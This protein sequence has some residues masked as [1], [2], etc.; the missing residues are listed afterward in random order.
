[1]N[2]SKPYTKLPKLFKRRSKKSG[3]P[4]GSLVH[5]GDEPDSKFEIRVIDYNHKHSEEKILNDVRECIKYKRSEGITWINI[6]GLHD[7][8]QLERL[9]NEYNIHPLV[10][11]DILNTNQ[12]PKLENYDNYVYIIL[13]FFYKSSNDDH[14]N[15]EQI[16]IIMGKSYVITFQEGIAGDAFETV[17]Q[18]IL[19]NKGKITKMPS[20]Y[21]VYSLI[22]AV[23]D[24]YF[25]LLDIIG[26]K[27]EKLEEELI[28]NPTKHTLTEIY[29]LKREML[30]LRKSI[31]PLREVIAAMERG[32]SSLFTDATRFYLRDIYD[33]T[34]N[35]I[36]TLETYR[37][38]LSGILDIYLS[39]MSNRLNEKIKYLT[40][41]TT[42]FIPTSLIAS[43]FGM[44]FIHLPWLEWEYGYL[45]I[46]GIM[47]VVVISMWIFF[48][49]KKLI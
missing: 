49:V 5:I 29:T 35:T 18:R 10:M 45:L 32:E 9:G 26:E 2:L 12:R 16:S 42:I 6:N 38:M 27:I 14:I 47:C 1:M 39:S 11:E 36:D 44:N 46:L 4:P 8:N 43:I 7:V 34:I 23:I 19:N 33:H 41:L 25:D 21:L 13:K 31:W 30:I 40:L 3:L 24:S 17:R 15:T 28:N 48:K 37:D 22:D 20:D